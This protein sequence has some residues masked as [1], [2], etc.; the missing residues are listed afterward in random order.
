M[1]N[2]SVKDNVAISKLLSFGEEKGK[3]AVKNTAEQIF[4]LSQERCPVSTDRLRSSGYIIETGDGYEVG[5]SCDYAERVDILPQSSLR[6]GI[7]HFFTSSVEDAKGGVKI[8]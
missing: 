7:A 2:I 6:S 3:E 5:Y 1:V 8:G 4:N